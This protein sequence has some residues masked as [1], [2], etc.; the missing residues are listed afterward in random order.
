MIL[1][2]SLVTYTLVLSNTGTGTVLQ[3]FLTDTLPS[4]ITFGGFVSDGGALEQDGTISWTGDM[5]VDME[6]SVVFTATVDINYDLY[7]ETITN[8]VEYASPNAGSGSAS[9]AFSIAGA[10]EV[11]IEKS[12]AVPE[13]L[14]PGSVVTYTLSLANIG[15]ASALNLAL[16]DTLPTGITFG[17][18]I[19]QNGADVFNGVITWDGDL[20]GEREFVFTAIVDYDPSGYGQPIMN[21]VEFTSTN[22]GSGSAAATFTVVPPI[23]SIDKSVV[24]THDPAL[25]GDPIAYTL[26]VHN[27]GTTGAV[28]V[29]IWDTLPEGVIGSNVDVTTTINTGEAYTITV[30][31]TLAMDV[32]RGSSIINTAYYKSGDLFGES[33][34]SFTVATLNKIYLP[35]IRRH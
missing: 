16:V 20:S 15:E 6:V 5:S 12:V 10:P 27:D 30:Q 32:M 23:L 31:A 24:T 7:G 13:V 2:G 9:A 17:A 21:T 8:T 19:L 26:V 18:W 25:P 22:A 29:H 28:G 34:A 3:T 4:G 35:L 1:P 33:T 11:T 14:N